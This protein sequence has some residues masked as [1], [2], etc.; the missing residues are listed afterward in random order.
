MM[1]YTST[2]ND[3]NYSFSILIK[4]YVYRILAGC[5]QIV[6]HKCPDAA[7]KTDL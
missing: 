7:D 6:G 2:L 1:N 5:F 4:L 3:I